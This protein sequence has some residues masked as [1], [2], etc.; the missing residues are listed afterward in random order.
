MDVVFT[1]DGKTALVVSNEDDA[2]IP[3]DVKSGRPGTP[4]RVGRS[5]VAIAR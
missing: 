3:I 2:I 1:S 5:P 4:I